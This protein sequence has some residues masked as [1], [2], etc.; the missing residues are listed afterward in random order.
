MEE[1]APLIFA[2]LCGGAF[3]VVGYEAVGAEDGFVDVG[4][5][6]VLDEVGGHLRAVI[7]LHVNLAVDQCSFPVGKGV[8]SF[9]LPGVIAGTGEI[10]N[11]EWCFWVC[12]IAFFCLE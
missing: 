9:V 5:E 6:E 7:V 4:V 2:L 8:A 12:F 10:G 3:F 11:A 1:G